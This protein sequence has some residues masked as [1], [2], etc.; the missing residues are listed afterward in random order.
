MICQALRKYLFGQVA[1]RPAFSVRASGFRCASDTSCLPADALSPQALGDPS[2]I[3]TY[4]G[5]APDAG[6]PRLSGGE[7]MLG[8]PD[9]IL[10]RRTHGNL[11]VTLV[12]CPQSRATKAEYQQFCDRECPMQ[13]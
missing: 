6:H 5:I 7:R 12:H 10:R 9:S 13:F 1:E 11:E 2:T 4:A 3:G 8:F